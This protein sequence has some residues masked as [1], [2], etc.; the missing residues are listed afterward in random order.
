[1]R[2]STRDLLDIAPYLS[3]NGRPLYGAGHSLSKKSLRGFFAK[4]LSEL[5]NNLL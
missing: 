4:L 5:Q 1:M 3:K 2:R